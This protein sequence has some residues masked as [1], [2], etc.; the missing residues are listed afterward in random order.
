M[1]ASSWS[2]VSEPG[3]W[4]YGFLSFLDFQI[5]RFPIIDIFLF[6]KIFLGNLVVRYRGKKNKG[7]LERPWIK[8]QGFDGHF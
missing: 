3:K 5:S 4:V 8:M 1:P 2:V 7:V 6:H